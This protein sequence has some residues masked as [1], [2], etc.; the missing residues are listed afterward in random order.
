[1]V[2]NLRTYIREQHKN[3]YVTYDDIIVFLIAYI[4]LNGL[5]LFKFIF[6]ILLIF[7]IT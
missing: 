4:Q 6:L 5:L 2:L 7:K 1:M 3:T